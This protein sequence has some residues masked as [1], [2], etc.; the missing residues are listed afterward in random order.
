MKRIP[1]YNIKSTQLDDIEFLPDDEHIIKPISNSSLISSLSPIDLLFEDFSNFKTSVCQKLNMIKQELSDV[2]QNTNKSD[3]QSCG[4]CNKANAIETLDERNY[5]LKAV[6][7][8][9]YKNYTRIIENFLDN[10]L[11]NSKRVKAVKH[12]S[13][14]QKQKVQYQ[15]KQQEKLAESAEIFKCSEFLIFLSLDLKGPT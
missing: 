13:E 8:F 3:K 5:C 11:P 2:K 1:T 7:S 4:D 12:I 6:A 15:E 9:C 14:N 10:I